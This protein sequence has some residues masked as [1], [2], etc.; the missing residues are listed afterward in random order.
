MYD[1]ENLHSDKTQTHPSSPFFVS[2]FF[3]NRDVNFYHV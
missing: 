2:T 1:K 3:L